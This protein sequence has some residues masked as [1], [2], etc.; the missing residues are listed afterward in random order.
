MKKT[1]LALAI[2]SASILVGCNDNNDGGLP[3][4]GAPAE[5]ITSDYSFIDEP[6]KGL[7]Y[8]SASQSGCTNEGGTFSIVAGES[9][10]FYIGRCDSNNEPTFT[11]NDVKIG[12][13][14]VPSAYTTPYDLMVAS[15]SEKANPVAIATLLKSLTSDAGTNKLDLSGLHLNENGED[16][17][18][19]LQALINTPSTDA[20]TVL[21]TALFTKLTTAN[22]SKAQ[23]LKNTNFVDKAVVE[24]ELKTT[25]SNMGGSNK[26]ASS[27]IAGK[28][29]TTENG[30]VY[31]F[32]SDEGPDSSFSSKGK[33]TLS[34][35]S[36]TFW[37][38]LN[39][40]FGMNG[41]VGDLYLG[42]SSA[43]IRL[44]DKRSSS[45]LVTVN[46]GSPKKWEI[47]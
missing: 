42:S 5:K 44:L 7:Y 3:S 23:P 46:N 17:R 39:R 27:D 2:M 26:F 10:D 28:T 19:E 1:T 16:V 36:E 6:V 38:I 29:A 8:E 21:N 31:I 41:A 13:V 9:V 35:G 14:R 4:S 22:A 18:T 24:A 34:D 37:G 40:D 15:N 12:T 33:L 32:G 45:L 30:T 20:T 47:K 43:T 11:D 25:L